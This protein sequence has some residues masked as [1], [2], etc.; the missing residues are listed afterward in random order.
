MPFKGMLRRDRN[1]CNEAGEQSGPE[2]KW[3]IIK[4]CWKKYELHQS[5]LCF[6]SFPKTEREFSPHISSR[7]A[8]TLPPGKGGHCL[9]FAQRHKSIHGGRVKVL[10]SK[11]PEELHTVFMYGEVGANRERRSEAI[12]E[13]L[14]LPERSH[15]SWDHF[16]SLPMKIKWHQK[17]G[18]FFSFF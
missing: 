17:Q 8:L 10:L 14:S 15:D 11:Q 3:E 5:V 2:R 1:P 6:R 18:G 13:D 4:V 16:G 7:A 9:C 12:K